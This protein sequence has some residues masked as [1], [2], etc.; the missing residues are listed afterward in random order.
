MENVTRRAF[1][2]SSA[3]I[4]A[5]VNPKLTKGSAADAVKASIPIT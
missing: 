4:A 2:G 1:I 5:T 3:A